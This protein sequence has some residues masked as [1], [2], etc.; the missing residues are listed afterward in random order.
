M[1]THVLLFAMG[2]LS[3][4]CNSQINDTKDRPIEAIKNNIVKEPKGEWKVDKEFD[5]KGNLI[6]YDSIYSWSSQDNYNNLPLPQR[7]SLIQSFK[8]RFF[9]DFSEFENQGLK[10]SLVSKHF[11]NNNFFESEFGSDLM[12]LDK[13]RQQMLE[14]Q[15]KILEKYHSKLIKPED[16]D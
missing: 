12:D 5:E 2:L 6:R 1:K 11:F 9:T 16:E 13:I 10:D 14:R 7:D 8:S 4:S 15:K 3:I